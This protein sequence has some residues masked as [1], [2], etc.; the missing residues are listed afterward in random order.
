MKIFLIIIALLISVILETTLIPFLALWGVGPN[1]V[2]V[3]VLILVILKKFEKTWWMIVLAGLFLDLL[4]GLPLGLVSLCLVSAAYFIDWF[5]RTVFSGLRFWVLGVLIILGS[6]TY[7]LLLFGLSMVFG[8]D[9]VF[10]LGYLLLN[11]AY[12]LLI[13]LIFYAGVK[14]VLG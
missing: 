8:V 2:L 13:G 6:L 5:N 9:S 10:N 4:V 12:N 7:N 3:L 14:K 11:M 1:L